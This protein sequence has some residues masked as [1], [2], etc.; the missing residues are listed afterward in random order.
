MLQRQPNT[1][2]TVQHAV[3]AEGVDF[4]RIRFIASLHHLCLQIHLKTD[5]R[6]GLYQREQFIHFVVA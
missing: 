4:K 2:E 6:I 3:A 5:P 1:V